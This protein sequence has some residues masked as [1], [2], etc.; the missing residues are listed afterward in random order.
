MKRVE[1]MENA[2]FIQNLQANYTRVFNYFGTGINPSVAIGLASQ[3][4]FASRTFS[5]VAFQ[6]TLDD[7]QQRNTKDSRISI[8]NNV[9]TLSNL[10]YKLVAHLFLHPDCEKEIERLEQNERYL[11]EVGFK[12]NTYRSIAALLLVDEYH[13]K[14]AKALYNEMRGYHRFL[15]GKDD[16]PF[17]VLLTAEKEGTIGLRAQTMHRYYKEL[18]EQGF[19]TGDELQALSQL[20]TLYDLRYQDVLVSYVVQLKMEF[21]KRHIRVKKLHYPY[22]G[23]L[24]LVATNTE[25]V[26][27]I[28][29]LHKELLTKKLFSGAKALALIVAIQQTIQGLVRV[30]ETIDLTQALEI[31][32]FMLEMSAQIGSGIFDVFTS[33][34]FS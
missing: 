9:T 2:V 30:K 1:K 34:L 16:I 5:G 12:K 18:R 15:T 10:G 26:Q 19:K 31:S 21:E 17:A 13:A 11:N 22:L 28:T 33:D 20:L 3:Y 4:T 23:L 8:F 27:E 32:N 7:F 25:V 14:R 6:K 29:D 24:A